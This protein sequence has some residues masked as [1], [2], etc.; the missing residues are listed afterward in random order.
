MDRGPS[1]RERSATLRWWGPAVLWAS[2]VLLPAPPAG[3]QVLSGLALP[4]TIRLF[5]VAPARREW[6]DETSLLRGVELRD[7]AARGDPGLHFEQVGLRFDI[8]GSAP[9]PAVAFSAPNGSGLRSWAAAAVAAVSIAYSLENS[10]KEPSPNGGFHETAEGFF[11]SKTYAGGADKAA[12]FVHY[13]MAAR[14]F[15]TTYSRLGYSDTTSRWLA[16]GTAFGTGLAT[17][18]GD[19]TTLFGFSFEDLLMDALG[20]ASAMGLSSTGWDDTFGFRYGTGVSQ[21]EYTG[22]CARSGEYGRDY[23]GEI[24]TADVKIAGAS[25]RLRLDPGPA[26]YLL[27]SMTYGT[28]GYRHAPAELQ[29]RLVGLEVGIDF[30]EILRS[31]RVPRE[32]LWGE[33]VYTFFDMI[34]LPYTAIGVRYDLNHGRWFGPTTGRTPFGTPRSH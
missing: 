9:P 29:Q 6:S 18:I 33:L 34:R 16:F 8:E 3:A 4:P 12:H 26:R 31:L 19:G 27:V 15:E 5:D 28:N 2:A 21:E 1:F 11:G 14:L 10:M 24:F 32:P 7:E 13:T 23:S 25:R 30:S 17:E 22:C 20:A